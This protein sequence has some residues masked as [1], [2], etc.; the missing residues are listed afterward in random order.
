MHD[1]VCGQSQCK[2]SRNLA[3]VN[4]KRRFFF[5][6]LIGVGNAL[7]NGNIHILV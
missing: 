4:E 1:S 5:D 3:T 2:N 6:I 7:E